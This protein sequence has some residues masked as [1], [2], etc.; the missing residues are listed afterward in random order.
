MWKEDDF[1][2]S[3]APG[4]DILAYVKET[5]DEFGVTDHI[6]F[7]TH[8]TRADWTTSSGRWHLA[9]E[10]G[11]RFTCGLAASWHL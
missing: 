9:T 8:V 11:R 5:A 6:L 2:L 7:G 3:I 4:A 1:I 10:D